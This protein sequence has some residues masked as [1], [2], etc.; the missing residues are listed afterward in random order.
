MVKRIFA[1]IGIVVGAVAA[2]TGS[3][4]GVMAL[5]GK[6][7]TPDVYPNAVFFADASGNMLTDQIILEDDQIFSLNVIG[8]TTNTEYG[9][10]KKDALV[11]FEKNIGF[12][13][14][15][16][17][18]EN[19]N[20]LSFV[21]GTRMYAVN[22]NEKIYYK[23]KNVHEETE[24][25]KNVSKRGQVV[26]KVRDAYDKTEPNSITLYIDR[27]IKKI[28][29][30]EATTQANN[31][32]NQDLYLGVANL[33]AED[34][35]YFEYEVNPELALYPFNHQSGAKQIE[36]YFAGTKNNPGTDYIPVNS[37]TINSNVLKDILGFD[38]SKNQYY[39]KA[40]DVTDY[41]FKIAA[42]KTYKDYYA[43]LPVEEESYFTRLS[44]DDMVV[45]NLTIHVTN[46]NVS[47]VS[48]GV[49]E[50]ALNLYAN[51]NYLTLNGEVDFNGVKSKNLR[52]AINPVEIQNIRYGAMEFGELN[53]SLSNLTQGPTVQAEDGSTVDLI[54]ERVYY[55]SLGYKFVKN[56]NIKYIVEGDELSV[57]DSIKDSTNKEYVCNNGV[58]VEYKNK[59]YLLSSGSYLD[60]YKYDTTNNHNELVDGEGNFKFEITKANNDKG[61]NKSWKIVC[62]TMPEQN[63]QYCFG[64]LVVNTDGTY[65]FDTTNITVNPIELSKT[66]KITNKELKVTY[67]DENVVAS[68]EL[69]FD[70]FIQVNNP[71]QV[72]YNALVLVAKENAAGYSVKVTDR[73]FEYNTI[74]Y[75]VVGEIDSTQFDNVIKA[76]DEYLSDVP[77]ELYLMQLKNSYN[78]TLFACLNGFTEVAN[79]FVGDPI[80][81]TTKHVLNADLLRYDD[82][83]ID[84]NNEI[85][86]QSTGHKITVSL[87]DEIVNDKMLNNI[88]NYYKLDINYK[89]Y[90]KVKVGQTSVNN[91]EIT[92]AV[93]VDGNIEISFSAG[94]CLVDTDTQIDI[95]I[96]G[97]A[98]DSVKIASFKVISSAPAT[99]VLNYDG[100]GVEL[101]TSENID[102]AYIINIAIG[103]AGGAYSYQYTL[104]DKDGDF[105]ANLTEY[106]LFNNKISESNLGFQ[107]A[108][109]KEVTHNVSYNF[110][111]P[112]IITL[113]N[114]T[115][116]KTPKILGVGQT[117]LAVTI[118]GA[119]R[120]IKI[121]VHADKFAW[122]DGIPTT[123]DTT[124]NLSEVVKLQCDGADVSESLYTLENLS[125]TTYGNGTLEVKELTSAEL[126]E[127]FVTYGKGYGYFDGTTCVLK[128]LYN[129]AWSFVRTNNKYTP[130]T[131]K[132][133]INTLIGTK[134]NVR[135][136]FTSN[137]QVGYNTEHWG[138]ERK[139][140][141]GTN[142]QVYGGDYALLTSQNIGTVKIKYKVND[143]A[144]LDM[145]TSNQLIVNVGTYTFLVY[146]DDNTLLLRTT[147]DVVPNALITAKDFGNKINAGDS[148]VLS[149]LFTAEY[150]PISSVIYGSNVNNL[151]SNVTKST[152]ANY[153]DFE[154]V[155]S[156]IV[157]G[158]N[159]AKWIEEIGKINT[160]DVQ[161]TYNKVVVYTFE[162]V[163]FVN[164]YKIT[165]L[166]DELTA[167]TEYTIGI[168]GATATLKSVK[169]NE[170]DVSV[171]GNTF[172]ISAI[173]NIIDDAEFE[174]K[175]DIIVNSV[176]REL[177]Y[178]GTHTIKPYEPQANSVNKDSETAYGVSDIISELFG[179][180]D[181]NKIS[182]ISFNERVY[183]DENGTNNITNS[184]LKNFQTGETN[185]TFS[186]QGNKK[187]VY[188][189]FEITYKDTYLTYKF[190]A[191]I[192]ITNIQSL[193]LNYPLINDDLKTTIDAT[194]IFVEDTNGVNEK[195]LL[196]KTR[197]Y[198]PVLI[199]SNNIGKNATIDFANIDENLL[200]QRAE[201][202]ANGF[203]TSLT[204]SVVA[205]RASNGMPT[206][207]NNGGIAINGSKVTF[208]STNVNVSG[209][210]VFKITS[211]TGNYDYYTIYL[212]KEES[213]VENKINANSQLIQDDK[214]QAGLTGIKLENL[215]I[216]GVV[217]TSFENVF[218]RPY[219]SNYHSFYLLD[220]K[221]LTDRGYAEALK[222]LNRNEKLDLTQE[223][224]VN[225]YTTI[226][227]AVVYNNGARHYVAGRI[228]LTIQPRVKEGVNNSAEKPIKQKIDSYSNGEYK[229]DLG[230]SPMVLTNAFNGATILSIEGVETDIVDKKAGSTTDLEVKKYT[231]KD[232]TFD[233]YYQ[234]SG[235][236]LKLTCT[237]HA[238]SVPTSVDKMVGNF[239]DETDGFVKTLDISNIVTGYNGGF[240]VSGYDSGIGDSYNLSNKT[241]TFGI[242]TTNRDLVLT[243]KLTGIVN[244]PTL[245]LNVRVLPGYHVVSTPGQNSGL[246]EGSRYITDTETTID[247]TSN[248]GSKIVI[249]ETYNSSAGYYTYTFGTSGLTVYTLTDSSVK[250]GYNIEKYTDQN[251]VQQVANYV[252][253]TDAVTTASPIEQ[254]IDFANG[255]NLQFTHLNNQKD[256]NL[257]IK[258]GDYYTG[259]LF[260]TVSST[261]ADIKPV[262]VVSGTDHEN[263]VSGY[264]ENDLFAELFAGS[265]VKI[266]LVKTDGTEISGVNFANIGFNTKTNP[267]YIV[268]S[269]GSGTKATLTDGYRGILFASVDSNSDCPLYL[270]SKTINELSA[271][272]YITYKYQIMAG[273][274]KEGLN[275][276]KTIVTEGYVASGAN[277]L[278]YISF[279][280]GSTDPNSYSKE[281]VVGQLVDSLN[282]G[283]NATFA[284]EEISGKIDSTSY[285]GTPAIVNSGNEYNEDYITYQYVGTNITFLIRYNKV[286]RIISVKISGSE[287]FTQLELNIKIKGSTDYILGYDTTTTPSVEKTLDLVFFNYDIETPYGTG[288]DSVYAG[289]YVDLFN[290][291]K[292]VVKD[293]SG[294]DKSS[295]ISL[296]Y[297]QDM[298]TYQISTPDPL[299]IAG[300]SYYQWDST[301]NRITTK[302]VAQDVNIYTVFKII[303]TISGKDYVV[304]LVNYNFKQLFN[305]QMTVNGEA[306]V[307]ND[308]PKLETNFVL[309]NTGTDITATSGNFPIKVQIKETLN[310]KDKFLDVTNDTLYF[311]SLIF[312]LHN[313]VKQHGSST[314]LSFAN[315]QIVEQGNLVAQGI[316]SINSQ[317]KTITF[318]K[319]YTGDILLKLSLDTGNGIYSVYWTIHVTGMAT[320]IER[321]NDALITNNQAAFNSGSNVTL[322]DDINKGLIPTGA[323]VA[324]SI[325]DTFKAEN[326]TT[327]TNYTAS[328]F[329]V[330]G[331][332]YQY[333]VINADET[334]DKGNKELFVES[335]TKSSE[336]PYTGN[337]VFP[338]VSI[339]W[340]NGAVV[341]YKITF[342]YLNHTRE[343][344]AAYWVKNVQQVEATNTVINVDDNLVQKTQDDSTNG[345]F[346]AT[347]TYLDLFYFAEVYTYIDNSTTTWTLSLND[348]KEVI[349]NDG[350]NLY[351]QDAQ[352]SNKFVNSTSGSTDY[353]ILDRNGLKIEYYENDTDFVAD[354]FIVVK[355]IKQQYTDDTDL[356]D[357]NP[358]NVYSV[359][360]SKY[361]TIDNF[362]SFIDSIY[363]IKIDNDEFD[364]TYIK[365][366]RFG[367][368]LAE[369]GNLFTNEKNAKL[370]V[371]DGDVEICSISAYNGSSGFRLYSSGTITAKGGMAI[372]D[373]FLPKYTNNM[374]YYGKS[375]I[376]VFNSP[377]TNFDTWVTNGVFNSKTKVDP[378]VEIKVPNGVSGENTYTLYNITYNG[379]AG[380]T[381]VCTISKDF[382]AL[383]STTDEN[384]YVV[385][386]VKNDSGED[387]F[388]V[389][390]QNGTTQQELD[391]NN[392][393]K[394]YG[395]DTGVLKPKS[396]PSTSMS[397]TASGVTAS[398]VTTT[399]NIISIENSTLQT[400]KNENPTKRYYD[401]VT[402]KVTVDTYHTLSLTVKFVLPDSTV[403]VSNYVT[404]NKVDIKDQFNVFTTSNSSLSDDVLKN[405]VGLI[406]EVGTYYA[407]VLKNE[408]GNYTGEIVLDKEMIAEYFATNVNATELVIAFDMTIVVNGNTSTHTFDLIVNEQRN[409]MFVDDVS[410]SINVK[411]VF[412]INDS[413]ATYLVDTTFEDYADI[414]ENSG[415]L[416]FDSAKIDEYFKNNENLIITVIVTISSVDTE[417]Y[418]VVKK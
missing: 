333:V 305:F 112:N 232:I 195:D 315:V 284:V 414:D 168:D 246:N 30:S 143:S 376:G 288:L 261:Y 186:I 228:I 164:K 329:D 257:T 72:S 201:L 56:S 197:S 262:Y 309:T 283:D 27:E 89:D 148:V 231:D 290:E 281:V 4:F 88:F 306:M 144:E 161:V 7:K 163:N 384:I 136:E 325:S 203:G 101:V 199:Y 121:N 116:Y 137:V 73:Y 76:N 16:L 393:I 17:C 54:A 85:F 124:I 308:N 355:N 320:I 402:A 77:T 381:N 24:I 318:N 70:E 346:S 28:Y 307:V 94:N 117:N 9:V 311:N 177:I 221:E 379:T 151:Y 200:T 352:N 119:T 397:V 280:M 418:I 139:L 339:Q 337:E 40:T 217:S 260:V 296:E 301:N 123:N 239:K 141:A 277:G 266:A 165:G 207:Y 93:Y 2:F 285:S 240:D 209:Y 210:V 235:V 147:F 394:C 341:I 302:P 298:S 310:D 407:N 192:T 12:D 382:L 180:P 125:Y 279:E 248:V 276:D 244:N 243:V 273:D 23:L 233:V 399:N 196:N 63:E 106:E 204:V 134:Q 205:Y 68:D 401:D 408:L 368:N 396:I 416:T 357:S 184:V 252:I 319:D 181:T 272:R 146:A 245:T 274:L 295:D 185:L 69:P 336:S 102:N 194:Y 95:Y 324:M 114:G 157:E 330:T 171:S 21:Q 175:F 391:L 149:D 82:N 159:E 172:T 13:L 365:D 270:Y 36:L 404:D 361:S 417:Y 59:F 256:M 138:T 103:Y 335:T 84:E 300:T 190:L 249:T 356:T 3:V 375:I 388:K 236:V 48:F 390:Y 154:L 132:F 178:T 398:S 104:T 366:G 182:S 411:S 294:V 86:E 222:T 51:N 230:S 188:L 251:G 395:M 57:I 162:N 126:T 150:Y 387:Y 297:V 299:P 353:Y 100:S 11:W 208:N 369:N 91:I 18:D 226:T 160:A 304:R 412:N 65:C 263:V 265:R 135:I 62:K 158:T 33:M 340:K 6:F 317:K 22:C 413:S 107:D 322:I 213:G 215:I 348:S 347:G 364:L 169:Y 212:S 99:I 278:D 92:G 345:T 269:V 403:N 225:G 377:T 350:L 49:E 97:L 110:E 46:S 313:R 220:A 229:V 111:N 400:Y 20:A 227:L 303:K 155:S 383:E 312:N 374:S 380:N 55:N 87:K 314:Q 247:Y 31:E 58:V 362:K 131:I 64:V 187:T 128:A 392:A 410:N 282:A 174:I 47:S 32:F 258:I 19:G 118:A 113:E 66:N 5:M 52:L 389:D 37:T 351:K 156:L 409:L 216:T 133:D 120:Y 83:V 98:E 241:L 343:C 90:F 331:T 96:E 218:G 202:T 415:V 206:Y 60:V 327:Y 371:Y 378:A 67:D 255:G 170:I 358:G 25:D 78:Q 53:S 338:N 61:A 145:P 152:F 334:G 8:S 359:F 140:Y 193:K 129:G 167:L 44:N 254:S 109:W 344:Y 26:L 264:R 323:G 183:D 14:I 35:F 406:E 115:D 41:N 242:G 259:N 271:S 211:A 234:I 166:G 289:H 79:L 224:A 363:K 373:I 287:S 15:E 153:G 105:I 292:I 130:L 321:S 173:N 34:Y 354:T 342:S 142:V 286:T 367:I 43:P 108:S 326:A 179:T 38:E 386:Y 50:I 291:G 370:A 219:N 349:L 74:K 293:A 253:D 75:Y 127:N 268:F 1:V 191:P 176:L 42:F 267:N 385:D 214:Y 80:T 250:I 10:N 122:V 316:I 328:T 45:T 189:E 238:I 372:S 360:T 81:I 198:E 405:N 275:T 29:V 223:V 332:K 237:Y 71:N 39:F